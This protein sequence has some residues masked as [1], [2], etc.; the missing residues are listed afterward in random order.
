MWQVYQPMQL[1]A[2]HYPEFDHFWQLELDMRFTGH[3]GRYLTALST[4]ARLEPRKQALERSLYLQMPSHPTPTPYLT[5][6][7]TTSHGSSFVWGPLRIPEIPP[8]GPIPPTASP[9]SDPFAWGVGEE[10]DA[11]VTSFCANA[12]AA[13]TWVFRDWIGGLRGG[14]A[15]PRFFCPPAITRTSR[16]L[17]LVAHE[18]QVRRAVRVPSEATP[19]SFALWHGLKMS[20]PQGPVF[21]RKEHDKE[22]DEG[23]W[24]G[25]PEKARTDGGVGPEVEE[26][27]SG[28]GLSFWW[29][30]DWPRKV[31]DAWQE[32]ERGEG[33]EWPWVV[34]REGGRVW[35]P[36]MMVHPMK[37][38]EGEP[39]GSRP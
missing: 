28:D 4:T 23:W 17:M 12:T 14:V 11:I 18:A 34:R 38:R 19:V 30:G 29:G 39:R 9:E 7:N 33:E 16:A 37:R 32:E 36:N 15:T 27:P 20:F 3:T 8:I 13:T 5:T 6:I 10:A 2:L 25:G 26:H 24:R 35:A 1:L 22:Y 31:F 21:Y